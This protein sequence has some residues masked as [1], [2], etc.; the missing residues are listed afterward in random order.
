MFGLGSELV[1]VKIR[2]RVKIKV[3]VRDP[4]SAM[5]GEGGVEEGGGG[6]MRYSL[7]I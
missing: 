4:R 5:S 6:R 7:S 2:V 3:Q 1:R